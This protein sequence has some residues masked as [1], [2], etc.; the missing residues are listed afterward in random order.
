MTFIYGLQIVAAR[1][2]L[3][4]TQAEL[5]E[6]LGI[7]V[8]QIVDLEAPDAGVEAAGA[9]QVAALFARLGVS[10][11]SGEAGWS[12]HV[13]ATGTAAAAKALIER[14]EQKRLAAAHGRRDLVAA[15]REAILKE[16]DEF[17]GGRSVRSALGPFVERFHETGGKP[18]VSRLS[19]RTLKRWLAVRSRKG[20]A[21]LTPAVMLGR[22][23]FFEVHPEVAETARVLVMANNRLSAPALCAELRK[24]HPAVDTRISSVDH[25]L[26]KLRR[27]RVI[28]PQAKAKNRFG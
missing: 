21:A 4:L 11:T 3:G 27:D 1:A 8:Q 2:S 6:L 14:I 24:R 22:R 9:E 16:F 7:G 28:D 26:A 20:S 15:A 23:S 18:G 10:V 12:M 19:E 25:F 5:A 17:R 13:A